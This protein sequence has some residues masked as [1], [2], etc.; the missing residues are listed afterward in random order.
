MVKSTPIPPFAKP[1]PPLRPVL[2]LL[3]ATDLPSSLLNTLLA[4]EDI[5]TGRSLLPQERPP[6]L[7]THRHRWMAPTLMMTPYSLPMSPP[8]SPT[9]MSIASTPR[10]STTPEPS[11]NAN[12]AVAGSSECAIT[13]CHATLPWQAITFKHKIERP[14][15]AGRKNLLDL[16]H[17]EESFL[18]D[19]KVNCSMSLL[20]RY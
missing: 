10:S 15:G 17:W 1:T 8:H 20:S 5:E 12:Q 7:G 4:H 14:K 9:Y 2:V 16:V 6:L 11:H 3:S 13:T 19:M 18:N